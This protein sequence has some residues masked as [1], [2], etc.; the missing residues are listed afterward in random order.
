MQYSQNIPLK[1]LVTEGAAIVVSILIAFWIDAWWQERGEQIALIEYL[2]HFENEVIENDQL[3]D[4]HIENNST[5]LIALHKVLLALSDN[6]QQPLPEAFKNDLGDALWIRSP[7]VGTNALKDLISSGNLRL[8]HDPNVKKKM[9]EY[10]NNVEYL[11]FSYGFSSS[12]YLDHVLPALSP[13]VSLSELGWSEYDH[14]L[15]PDGE[16]TGVTPDAPYATNVSGLRSLRTWNA[17][18]NWK[19]HKIDENNWLKK[20]KE[21]GIALRGLL[22]AE[23]EHQSQ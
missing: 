6:N 14:H 4:K 11:D 12:I 17:L 3:I 13:Y 1:R 22:R 8:V 2:V 18:F 5:D 15:A 9:N 10:Q 21:S 7:T 19:T 20:T 16:N 23:I